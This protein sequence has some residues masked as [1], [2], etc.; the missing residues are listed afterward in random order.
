MNI[1][2]KVR[3]R[4]KWFWV[5]LIPAV[6]LLA[7]Q[8]LAIFGIQLDFQDVQAQLLAV[9]ETVFLIL[10]ILGVIVDPTTKGF[11]DSERAMTYETPHEDGGDD[12]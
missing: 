5:A 2:W 8:V 1:N 4:S 11:S 7:Q 6:L 12:A 10:G 9:V 3:I